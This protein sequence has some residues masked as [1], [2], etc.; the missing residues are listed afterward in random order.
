MNS[1][2]WIIGAWVNVCKPCAGHLCATLN[3][4]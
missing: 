2:Y 1:V 3:L 4:I